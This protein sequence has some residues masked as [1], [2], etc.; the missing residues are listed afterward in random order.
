MCIRFALPIHLINQHLTCFP[1]LVIVNNIAVNMRMQI[2]LPDTDSISFKW[3]PRSGIAGSYDSSAFNFLRKLHTV[4]HNSCTNLYSHQQS[5]RVLFHPYPH[6]HLLLLLFLVTA[7]L[8]GVRWYL[9]VHCF[10]FVYFLATHTACGNSW[11]RDQ[12]C[13]TVVTT[14]DP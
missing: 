7:S 10:L 12:T 11:A 9:I 3:I 13:T 2:C 5:T 14:P 4:F 1:I 6:L 8:A